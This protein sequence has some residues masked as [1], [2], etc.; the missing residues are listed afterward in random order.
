MMVDV[1]DA[2]LHYD[3]SDIDANTMIAQW[4]HNHLMLTSWCS[5]YL[6]QPAID[7]NMKML[8]IDVKYATLMMR[9]RC[10]YDESMML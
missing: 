2:T 10:H 5:S 1:N 7:A 9:N 8:D 4:W 6:M 3:A